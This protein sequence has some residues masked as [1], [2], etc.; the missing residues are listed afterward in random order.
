M[1]KDYRDHAAN[2]RTYLAWIRTAIAVMAFGFLIEK[3]NLFIAFI[4][5]SIGDETSY[6]SSLS[7]ELVG[8]GLFLAGILIIACATVRFFATKKAIESDESIRYSVKKTNI[9]LSA[10]MILIALFLLVYMSLQIIG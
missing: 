3:F 2:E 7:V 9:I 6:P 1:I 10:L 8:L 4:G 5:K